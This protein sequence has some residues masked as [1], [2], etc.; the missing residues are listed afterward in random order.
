MAKL[1]FYGADSNEYSVIK[2]YCWLFWCFVGS[3]MH[4]YLM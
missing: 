4:N 1:S 3:K 2:L